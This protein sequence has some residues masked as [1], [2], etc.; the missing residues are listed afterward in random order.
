VYPRQQWVHVAAVNDTQATLLSK[1]GLVCG[2]LPGHVGRTSSDWCVALCAPYACSV[3]CV[4]GLCV[5]VLL[6][7]W[8]GIWQAADDSVLRTVAFGGWNSQYPKG[9]PL[10]QAVFGALAMSANTS[11][12]KCAF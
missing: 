2:V 6:G 11:S 7:L 12:D 3:G 5:R 10:E 4:S 1:K 8:N 9:N